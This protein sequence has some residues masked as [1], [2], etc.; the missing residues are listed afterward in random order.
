[1]PDRSRDPR[2]EGVTG[3]DHAPALGVRGAEVL[4][5]RWGFTPFRSSP[6]AT[7]VMFA[8]ALALTLAFA[9]LLLAAP[10]TP[11]RMERESAELVD[12][13]PVWS[14]AAALEA[15]VPTTPASVLLVAGSIVTAAF[16]AYSLAIVVAWTPASPRI[17]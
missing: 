10:R 5:R 1:Y 2:A 17:G 6:A 12:R 14:A 15:V 7:A 8:L 4:R 16:A 13:L 3:R 9:W 11:G